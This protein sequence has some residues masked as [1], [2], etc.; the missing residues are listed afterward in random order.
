M[1]IQLC[2]YMS[3]DGDCADAM[4]F[5]AQVLGAKLEALITYGDMP[6]EMPMPAE[7]AHR[8]MHAYLVH[9]D[10][11]LMAGDAPPGVPFAGIQGCM[12]AITYPTVAEATRVFNALADGGK[13]IMPLAETFWA[14]TFGM[15]TD[16][17][18]TPW[19]VNGGPREMAQK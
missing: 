6:G 7:H 15:V 13:V 2:A 4:K 3:Y 16:R 11:A 14:D 18:G 5:Y 1:S 12:L 8:V 10:F 17:F 9:P 19:G